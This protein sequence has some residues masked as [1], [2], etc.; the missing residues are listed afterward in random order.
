MISK[1]WFIVAIMLGIQSDGR[2]DVYIFKEPKSH[3]H[4]HSAMECRD[5]I[6]DNPL[7]IIETLGV[8]YGGRPIQKV[9]CVPEENVRKFIF[10]SQALDKG[11][12]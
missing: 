3:G 4:F 6:R 5:H 1:A 7:P 10:Q 11:G 9:M 8:Q 12:L 2:Q